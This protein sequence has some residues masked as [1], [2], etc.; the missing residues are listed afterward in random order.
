MGNTIMLHK[1]HIAYSTWPLARFGLLLAALLLASLLFSACGQET[2]IYNIGIY[3][4]ISTV[5]GQ[6]NRLD[7]L[8]EG[9]KSLGFV[10]GVNFKFHELS[11]R[12]L[13]AAQQEPAL[14]E[15]AAKNH[16]IYW[17]ASDTN[18]LTLRKH[19]TTKPIVVAGL[20]SPV[21]LGLVKNLAR[22]EGNITGVGNLLTEFTL[23]RLRLLARLNAGVQKVYILYD[24]TDPG[25]VNFLP[26]VREE[27][28]R[29]NLGLIEKPFTTDKAAAIGMLNSLNDD[30]A[31]A[32][33]TLGSVK[34]LNSPEMVAPFI[35]VP[36]REKILRV[37]SVRLD[38]TQGAATISY[39]GSLFWQGR[40][41]A[42]Y[43]TKILN[44]SKV[45][46]LPVEQVSKTELL[47]SQKMLDRWGWKFP[48]AFM[49]TVDEVIK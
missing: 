11:I 16:H 29:L 43:L 7:G 38:I 25:Q 46:E 10:E 48:E 4:G 47:V 1:T 27:A 20:S 21:E 44:G 37:R 31:Q 26:K 12:D 45:A 33:L 8:K 34:V 14:K 5:E 28:V 35:E 9:L 41:S 3:H 15:F 23:D 40:Q 49:Q 17:T 32:E 39:G 13:P 18:T 24:A 42:A 30:E 19:V 6:K 22:P 2:K 36:E